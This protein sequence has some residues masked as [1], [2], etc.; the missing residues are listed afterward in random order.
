MVKNPFRVLIITCW[1]SLILCCITKLFGAN[2]FIAHT[3]NQTFIDF[4]N[5]VV[6][7]AFWNFIIRFTVNV[8]SS[9]IY[10]LAVFQ[11]NKPNLKWFI[12]LIIYATLKSIWYKYQ[13]LFFITDLVMTIGLPLLIDYKRWYI[14]IL[15]VVLTLAFQ[16][17]SMLLKMNQYSMFDENL[18]VG[19]IL[20]I[21]YYIMLIL[22]WLYSLY[23]KNRN[24]EV[25]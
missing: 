21:D 24:K 8:I 13:V 18:V 12:P 2:W 10:Y 16:F 15:G 23:L 4:C 9:S 20:S 17:I 1:V 19:L 25:D 22:Y 6:N 11:Q 5:F 14:I 3:D 7:N